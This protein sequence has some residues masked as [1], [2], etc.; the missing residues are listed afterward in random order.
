MRGG[1]AGEGFI[2][3]GRQIDGAAQAMLFLESWSS[4]RL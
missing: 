2:G 1:A 3:A 4:V